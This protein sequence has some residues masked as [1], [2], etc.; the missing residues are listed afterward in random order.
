MSFTLSIQQLSLYHCNP[1]DCTINSLSFT[2]KAAGFTL[3]SSQAVTKQARIKDIAEKA[4]VSSTEKQTTEPYV[5]DG[6][7]ELVF[8]NYT[9]VEKNE[10]EENRSKHSEADD[11]R[12][13]CNRSE[14]AQSDQR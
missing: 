6:T 11:I 5:P 3:I 14:S 7:K 2:W 4:V 10:I 13:L 8:S 1:D 9:E 12:K